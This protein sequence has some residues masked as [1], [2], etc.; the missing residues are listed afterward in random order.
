[1]DGK[2]IVFRAPASAGSTFYNYKGENSIVLLALVDSQYNFTYVDVGTNG[3]ISD[4][5]VFRK[6]T[7]FSAITNHSLNIPEETALPERNKMVP[8][9]IVADAAFPLLTNILKPYPFR[10]MS[11]EQ[12]IFNYRLSRARRVVENVF[13]ILANRFRIFLTTIS[14][15]VDKVQDITLACCVLHNF[16]NKECRTTYRSDDGFDTTNNFKNGLSQQLGNRPQQAA[17]DIR[18]EFLEYFNGV[19]SVPWQNNCVN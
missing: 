13:G 15:N 10:N 16:L 14:L 8:H 5:G 12:R 1:M 4:G 3:R 11:N 9:V 17:I 18:Q 6:S 2:H 19:G 7:L